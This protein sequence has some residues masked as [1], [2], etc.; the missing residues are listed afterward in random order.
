MPNLFTKDED[1][2]K[3]APIIGFKILQLLQLRE[4]KRVSI[5]DIAKQLR[6]SNNLGTKSI[7]YGMIF[8]YSLDI[9]DF[10]EPYIIQHVES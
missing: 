1:L 4:D 10:D 7:Y 5:Y 2:K 6:Q 9:I 8:L 3:S